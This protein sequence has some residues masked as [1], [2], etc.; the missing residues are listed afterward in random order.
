MK[1]VVLYV[2]FTARPKII[3]TTQYQPTHPT[4][5]EEKDE[6]IARMEEDTSLD[7]DEEPAEE[8]EIDFQL[9]TH[10]LGKEAEEDSLS[11]KGQVKIKIYKRNG[12]SI[13]VPDRVK[14]LFKLWFQCKEADVTILTLKEGGKKVRSVEEL[15]RSPTDMRD[16]YHPE[17]I[18]WGRP[19]IEIYV[20]VEMRRSIKWMFKKIIGLSDVAK[21]DGFSV[22]EHKL[23]TY[24]TRDV[25]FFTKLVTRVA[26]IKYRKGI[27][28]AVLQKV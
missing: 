22:A 16:Y 24:M 1:I 5:E 18:R 14:N 19:A 28:Q 21:A 25:G 20:R 9:E 27:I 23:T 15:P 26:D 7:G 8:F 12:K 2:F 17:H 10:D 13:H 11:Y 4:M 3:K 6:K